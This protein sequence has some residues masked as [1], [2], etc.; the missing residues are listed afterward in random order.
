MLMFAATS[1]IGGAIEYRP[2]FCRMGLYF[3]ADKKVHRDD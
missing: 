1:A 3:L 2:P